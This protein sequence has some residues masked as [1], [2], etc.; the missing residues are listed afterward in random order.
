MSARDDEV[1]QYLEE[2]SRAQIKRTRELLL[3]NGRPD[4]VRE[5]DANLKDV[6]TGVSTARGIWHALSGAQR[7]VLCLLHNT[8]HKLVRKPHLRTFYDALGGHADAETKAA[9]VRTVR[10]LCSR[11]LLACEGPALDPEKVVV[12]TDHGR[13]VLA[14][15][16]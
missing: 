16:K 8:G 13:F 4:L 12:L 1:F 7:R 5:L 11:E 3:E 2:R 9:G 15:G 10:A 6:R 14:R